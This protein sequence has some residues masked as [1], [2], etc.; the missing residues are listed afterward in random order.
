MDDNLDLLDI[1][2][3][4]LSDNDTS[5]TFEPDDL[6]HSVNV[7]LVNGWPYNSL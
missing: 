7:D 3:D 2:N 6:T 4:S 5:L 1:T